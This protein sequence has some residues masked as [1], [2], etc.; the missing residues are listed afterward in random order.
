MDEFEKY[1]KAFISRGSNLDF[2]NGKEKGDIYLNKYVNKE[3]GILMNA[4]RYYVEECSGYPGDIM[5]KSYFLTYLWDYDLQ[6]GSY[7][8]SEMKRYWGYYKKALYK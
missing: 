6:G 5:W 3:D 1:K 8:Y 2:F 7:R 4:Y